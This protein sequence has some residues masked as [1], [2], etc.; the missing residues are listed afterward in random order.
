M[1]FLSDKCENTNNESNEC[2][3]QAYMGFKA[4]RRL[5]GKYYLATNSA[6][7][8]GRNFPIWGVRSTTS[9]EEFI[10][11]CAGVFGSLK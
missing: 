1:A 9:H 8:F 10:N 2:L 3:G 4:D 11:S 7:P 6:S 5:R